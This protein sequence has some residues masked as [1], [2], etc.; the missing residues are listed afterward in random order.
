M[1]T[2]Q[3]YLKGIKSEI[4]EV[5]AAEVK[6]ELESTESTIIDVREQNE[7]VQGYVP[8]ATWIPRGFL[9][10]KIENKQRDRSAPIILY[11]AGGVRSA[12]AARS[13]IELGYTNVT[14]M[15]GGFVMARSR[16]APVNIAR[17]FPSAIEL[18]V[19]ERNPS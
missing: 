17:C 7:Y 9:E 5:S 1:P 13:L 8:G 11:C 14:S 18:R 19:G 6:G 16:P 4:S 10:I 15:A 3:N 12:L 2:F